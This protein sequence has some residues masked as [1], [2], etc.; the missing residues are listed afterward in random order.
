MALKKSGLNKSDEKNSSKVSADD[1][2]M[3]KKDNMLAPKRP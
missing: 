3:I 1:S 2:N